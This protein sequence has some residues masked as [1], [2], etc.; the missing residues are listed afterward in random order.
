VNRR[1]AGALD[2]D[3]AREGLHVDASRVAN[4]DVRTLA[5]GFEVAPH[6]TDAHAP[7]RAARSH[8]G[9]RRHRHLEPSIVASAARRRLQRGTQAVAREA[10]RPVLGAC[11]HPDLVPV[12]ADHDHR[13]LRAGDGD[14]SPCI[15]GDGGVERT[16]RITRAPFLLPLAIPLRAL[17]IPIAPRLLALP[18]ALLLIE[19]ALA[20]LLDALPLAFAR[21]GGRLR[22][23]R[24]GGRQGNHGGSEYKMAVHGHDVLR[25]ARAAAPLSAAAR[26]SSR[27]SD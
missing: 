17:T 13:T 12:R 1:L 20:R 24:R 9:T 25:Y 8:P 22:R 6:G 18:V 4:V 16:G 11:A 21:F 5:P 2:R 14:R 27:A 3:V 23:A 26:L 15:E 7:A 10:D 19:L